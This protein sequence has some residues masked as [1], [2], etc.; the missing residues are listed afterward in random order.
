[1][2]VTIIESFVTLVI[3][4]IRTVV[5]TVCGWVTSIVRTFV[6]VAKKVCKWLPWPLNKLCNWVTELV[7]VITEV[8]EWVCKEVITT[9]IDLVEVVVRYIIYIIRWICWVVEWVIR[10]VDML[11]CLIGVRIR[12]YL[13]VCVKILMDDEDNKATTEERVDQIIKRAGELLDQ[14]NVEICVLSVEFTR[15]GDLMTG[16]S[17][18]VSQLFSKA[19][20]WFEGHSC[21]PVHFP[22]IWPLTLFFVDS[23]KDANACTIPRTSYIVLTDGANGA[24][25][26][27]ELG[28]HA[29]LLHRDDPNNIMYAKPSDT[30]DQLTKWQ[31]CMIRSS[32]FVSQMRQ[33]R[34]MQGF[35][36]RIAEIHRSYA[37]TRD[38][39]SQRHRK[40]A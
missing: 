25:L 26:V 13:H 29:D 9:I 2:F 1:M 34:K 30:K 21:K 24:S 18:S 36:K 35:G 6:E 23:L 16:V 37:K 4:V 31:C 17:C 20:H 10:F 33:C 22:P 7:E 32:A 5:Q 39:Q 28:H 15:K 38:H 19:Y 3:E 14:C 11:F 40:D 12:R 27:H 8:V